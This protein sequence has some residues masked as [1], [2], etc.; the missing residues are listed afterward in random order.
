MYSLVCLH[1]LHWSVFLYIF[2]RTREPVKRTMDILAFAHFMKWLAG[3]GSAGVFVYVCMRGCIAGWMHGCMEWCM[4]VCRHAGVRAMTRLSEWAIKQSALVIPFLF[5]TAKVL[6]V[7][8]AIR[9][10]A[11]SSMYLILPLP[12]HITTR[13]HCQA[14]MVI[15]Q[16][17]LQHHSLLSTIISHFSPFNLVISWLLPLPT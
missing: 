13:Y 1:G 3:N 15:T 5:L 6:V 12:P 2:V 17:Y 9:K 10:L 4:H 14:W 11:V 8:K 7:S 16:H